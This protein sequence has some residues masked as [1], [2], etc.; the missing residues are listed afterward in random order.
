[1]VAA[2]EKVTLPASASSLANLGRVWLASTVGRKD[3]QILF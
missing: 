1:M 3:K 2:I